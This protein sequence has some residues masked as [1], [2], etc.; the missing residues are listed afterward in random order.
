MSPVNTH[1]AQRRHLIPLLTNTLR[2]TPPPPLPRTS[3]TPPNALPQP[4]GGWVGFLDSQ[5]SQEK[6]VVNG[7]QTNAI[8]AQYGGTR[9]PA[10][11]IWR[12]KGR[13]HGPEKKRSA[14]GAGQAKNRQH[15]HQPS[16][17]SKPSENYIIKQNE[18]NE[19]KILSRKEVIKKITAR[20]HV[21]H[22]CLRK[23]VL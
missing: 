1:L 12:E 7:L 22:R 9:N 23:K 16:S 14:A 11:S 10:S 20:L 13:P 3:S 5:D 15:C 19:V 6:I 4:S 18:K 21:F 2:P 8:M 17:P